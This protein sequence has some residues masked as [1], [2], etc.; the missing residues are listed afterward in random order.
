MNVL[1]QLVKVVIEKDDEK[2]I[3]EYK[4]SQLRFKRKHK[5]TKVEVND[6]ELKKLENVFASIKIGI[7]PVPHPKSST[8]SPSFRKGD[9]GI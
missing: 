8:L 6:E 5:H 4:V 1:R 2:E 3:Q 9:T 7:I